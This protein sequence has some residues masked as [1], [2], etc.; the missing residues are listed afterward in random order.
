MYERV[1]VCHRSRPRE[2][3][4]AGGGLLCAGIFAVGATMAVY[5]CWYQLRFR[6]FLS[7]LAAST[8]Y[9]Y[10][11]G[12]LQIA[13]DGRTL[14]VGGGPLSPPPPARAG[15]GPGRL[16]EPPAWMPDAVLTYGDG[17]S[18][19]LW[20]VELEGYQ[21]NVKE[22]VLLRYVDPAGTVYCYDTDGFR[23]SPLVS[24]LTS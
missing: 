3:L 10:Q 24:Q 9:A 19:E 2:S 4:L 21:T 14:P 6:Q 12:T 5:S 16:V 23:L 11:N 17:S 7:D 1:R 13:A 22:G 8:V 18:L 20:G 15:D